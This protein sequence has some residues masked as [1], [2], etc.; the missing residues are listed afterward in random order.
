[1][2]CVTKTHRRLKKIPRVPSEDDIYSSRGSIAITLAN[3]RGIGFT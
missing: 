1:M 2:T 3:I